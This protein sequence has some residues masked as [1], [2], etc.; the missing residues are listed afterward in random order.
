MLTLVSMSDTFPANHSLTKGRLQR[1]Y[2]LAAGRVRCPRMG[3]YTLFPGQFGH[4]PAGTRTGA[5]G[6]SLDWDR[7]GR[8]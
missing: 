6:A 7:K 5:G 2:L 1:G 8:L 4:Q 3:P